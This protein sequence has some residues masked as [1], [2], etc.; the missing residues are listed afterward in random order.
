MKIIEANNFVESD[1]RSHSQCCIYRLPGI[2]L[3]F[4]KTVVVYN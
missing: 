1:I 3:V 2:L 4:W